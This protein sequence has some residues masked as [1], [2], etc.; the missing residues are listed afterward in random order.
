MIGLAASQRA[1]GFYADSLGDVTGVHSDLPGALDDLL[2]DAP[3]SEPQPLVLTD[4]VDLPFDPLN[5]RMNPAAR[6]LSDGVD[7]A[8]DRLTARMYPTAGA[9]GVDQRA[10]SPAEMKDRKRLE[11]QLFG[12]DPTCSC[13][14]CQRPAVTCICGTFAALAPKLRAPSPS[15]GAPPI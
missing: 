9:D 6:G 12:L 8:Y 4:G 7:T 13:P 5:A 3:L 10:A 2:D 11:E 1:A 15:A 14:T